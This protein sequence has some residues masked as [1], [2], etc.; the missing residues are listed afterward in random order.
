MIERLNLIEREP[1][2][3]TY[4]TIVKATVICLLLGISLGAL[5]I[6]RLFL[7]EKQHTR[8]TKVH[9][10]LTAKRDAI[11]KQTPGKSQ[12]EF[13][14]IRDRILDSPKWGA[15]IHDLSKRIPTNVW[16]TALKTAPLVAQNTIEPSRRRKKDGDTKDDIESLPLAQVQQIENLLTL[17]GFAKKAIEVSAFVKGLQGSPYVTK[18]ALKNTEKAEGGFIFEIQCVM[19]TRLVG[20]P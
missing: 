2:T 3:P 1:F 12:G 6:G 14:Q 15:L 9:Q 19:M 11:M 13:A 8:H 5:N 18:V 7:A 20:G 4:S 10:E 17:S 16:L